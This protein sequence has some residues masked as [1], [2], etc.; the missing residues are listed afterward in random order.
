MMVNISKGKAVYVHRYSSQ[1]YI[2]GLKHFSMSTERTTHHLFLDG[3]KNK[4]ENLNT[5][6]DS[7]KKKMRTARD[8]IRL[9]SETDFVPAKWQLNRKHKK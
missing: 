3:T 7:E 1:V 2:E 6:Q 4:T 5:F 9:Q 8:E